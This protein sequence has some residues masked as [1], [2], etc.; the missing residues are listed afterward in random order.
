M[1][2]YI[3]INVRKFVNKEI[4]HLKKVFSAILR[5]NNTALKLARRELLDRLE[6]MNE[7]RDQLR[8]QSLTFATKQDLQLVE[9]DIKILS[10]LVFIILGVLILWQLLITVGIIKL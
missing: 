10:R 6:R 5:K 7:F 2:K 1:G 9:K 3:N 4:K 8:E